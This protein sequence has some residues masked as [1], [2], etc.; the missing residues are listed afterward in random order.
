[1]K[2]KTTKNK[3][4]TKREREMEGHAIIF[5]YI[6]ASKANCCCNRSDHPLVKD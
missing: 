6:F 2:K 4:K 3:H 1:M 5:N